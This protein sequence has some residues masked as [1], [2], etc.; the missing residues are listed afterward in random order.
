MKYYRIA[1]TESK[2]WQSGAKLS[3]AGV[4]SRWAQ[5]LNRIQRSLAYY[6]LQKRNSYLYSGME[7]RFLNVKVYALA[8]MA[9]GQFL[10]TF[11]AQYGKIFPSP[12]LLFR[13][14]EKHRNYTIPRNNRGIEGVILTAFFQYSYP[15]TIS[16]H[17][18][19]TKRDH[20]A[21]T[22]DKQQ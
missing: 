3:A 21:Y 10:A 11:I 17:R 18:I 7:M 5:Q 20:N 6:K 13:T 2:N 16:E 14:E 1:Q 12:T 4:N 8:Y 22:R 15:R 9:A 19:A